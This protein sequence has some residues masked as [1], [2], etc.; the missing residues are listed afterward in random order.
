MRVK[1]PDGSV[2]NFPDNMGEEEVVRAI[3]AQFGAPNA[4]GNGGA[5]A[6]DPSITAG[7]AI[8]GT[9]PTQGSYNT[10]PQSRRVGLSQSDTLNP[11]PALNTFANETMAS[12][13]VAGPTLQNMGEN[14]DAWLEN[15]IYGKLAGRTEPMTR[16]GVAAEN[17]ADA[18]SN[19]EAA[20]AGRIAGPVATYLALSRLPGGAAALGFRGPWYA[21][22]PA[23]L[24]SNQ[25]INTADNMAHGQDPVEAFKNALVPS[26]MAAPFAL[27]GGQARPNPRANAAAVMEREGVPLSGGQ[28]TGNRTL[29]FAESE[30]GGGATDALLERQGEAFTRAALSRA[31][32]DANRATPEVMDQAYTTIGQQFDDLAARN[33]LQ[34][35]A[36]LVTD[37]SQMWRRFEGVTNESTRPR[38]VENLLGDISERMRTGYS[39]LDG[40]WFKST[41]SEL[42]RV[43]RTSSS[44]ELKEAV[45][46]IMHAMDDAMERSI[47]RVNP[48]DLGAW[49]ETR[50]QW[51]NLLVL[52]DAA[53]RAGP[54]AVSGILTP[55]NLRM[56]AKSVYG[57]RGYVRGRGDLNELSRSGVETMTPLP[58]SGTAPRMAVRTAMAS[59]FT[60]AG[61]LAGNDAGG[62]LG[63]IAAGAASSAIPFLAGRG[64]V[65]P[66]GRAMARGGTPINRA[67]RSALPN[68]LARAL[69]GGGAG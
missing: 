46:D 64:L 36:Q 34:T 14:V 57:K 11:L 15:N 30:L 22:V 50:N 4:P 7:L 54:Q 5:P 29:Q 28:A 68:L 45:G 10:V 69:I 48:A 43:Q 62:L 1:L 66:A 25:A 32:V 13:P 39:F 24:G 40:D 63:G 56:A 37:L 2:G 8:P 3:Q 33:G 21:R 51:R 18:R 53:S 35:D 52:E 6:N 38:F 19:P 31:G 23:A 26:A 27:F 17:V 9:T 44:P 49:R 41:R 65:S 16:E 55:A 47:A 58:Q 59:P 12:V 60:I 42:A 67:A 20:T 61:A